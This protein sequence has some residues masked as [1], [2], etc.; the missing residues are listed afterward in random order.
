MVRPEKDRGFPHVSL[1]VLM[2]LP[3]HFSLFTPGSPE[4]SG[5]ICNAKRSHPC[6]LAI[7][8]CSLEETNSRENMFC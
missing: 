1:Q 6:S 8:A 2:V 7:V 5:G 4:P 3:H